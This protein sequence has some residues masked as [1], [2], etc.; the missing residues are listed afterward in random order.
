[1]GKRKGGMRVYMVVVFACIYENRRMKS[2]E[3]VLRRKAAE[4]WRK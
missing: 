1:V 2:V 4:R 3:I